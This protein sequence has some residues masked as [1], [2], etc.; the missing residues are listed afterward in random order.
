MKVLPYINLKLAKGRT[1]EQKQEF[2][3]VVTREAVRIFDVKPEWVTVVID[4]YTRDNWATGGELHCLKFGDGYG[5]QGVK[6]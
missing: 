2:V 1:L 6:E 3:E 5:K 4:E